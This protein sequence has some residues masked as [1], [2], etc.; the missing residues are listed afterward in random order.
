MLNATRHRK[1]T[2]SIYDSFR[3]RKSSSRDSNPCLVLV[4]FS[5]SFSTDSVSLDSGKFDATKTRTKNGPSKQGHAS[6]SLVEIGEPAIHDTTRGAAGL[7]LW[8]HRPW[9]R[10]LEARLMA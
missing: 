6:E 3:D 9:R 7:P 4:A 10:G 5:P 2:G 8:V 1:L